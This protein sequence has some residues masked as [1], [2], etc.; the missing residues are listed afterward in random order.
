MQPTGGR[1]SKNS[2]AANAHG[3]NDANNIV[4]KLR[5]GAGGPNNDGPKAAVGTEIAQAKGSY[6]QRKV[7]LG[8]AKSD[9]G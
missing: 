1:P 7:V 4:P 2:A 8:L 5:L 9:R 3:R 6:G